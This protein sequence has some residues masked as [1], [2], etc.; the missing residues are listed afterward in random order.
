MNRYDNPAQRQQL[1]HVRDRIAAKYMAHPAVNMVDIGFVEADA[2]ASVLDADQ[3]E[4]DVDEA[5]SD[6]QAPVGVRIHVRDVRYTQNPQY[7]KQFPFQL[8]GVR[9]D[10]VYG[11]YGIGRE[12][13]G[14]E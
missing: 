1:R 3:P 4:P 7:R 6:Q 13:G 10:V 14:G 5:L 12:S 2:Q 8:E 9:I 11:S